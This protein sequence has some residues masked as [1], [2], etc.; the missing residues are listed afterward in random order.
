MS[1]VARVQCTRVSIPLIAPIR[2]PW[3]CRREATRTIV[4]MITDD[5]THGVGET[6]GEPIVAG[7]IEELAPKIIGEDP[8]NLE[9]IMA[10]VQM[11]PYFSGYV[12]YAAIAG[13]EMALWDIQGKELGVPVYKL[14]GGKFRGEVPFAGYVFM[15][16]AGKDGRGGEESPS[17][18]VDFSKRMIG[19]CGFKVIKYK[20]GVMTPEFDLEVMRAL[21]CELGS[22]VGLRIDVNGLWKPQTALR[23]G[24][25]MEELDLEYAEDLT[26]GLDAMASVRREVSIPFATNMCVVT[27]EQI[28]MSV[29]INAIDVILGDVHKWGGILSTK[30][31]AAVC[32]TFSLGMSLH[33]GA[34]LGISTAATL[35]VAAS[36]PHLRFAAD[37]HYH[38]LTDDIIAGGPL[39]YHN[40]FMIVPEGPGLGVEIDQE[41]LQ[42][43]SVEDASARKLEYVIDEARPGWFP[44]KAAW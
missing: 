25:R 21:R 17:A 13:I 35:H 22:D 11:T 27:F 24:K 39:K 30:K 4:Q 8:F 34:E 29:K 20:G 36:T 23:F 37:S 19:E 5:G 15:R 44:E 1:N 14:L 43:Y 12:G 26:W 2:W 38:H 7:I 16:Y 33:S 40:G 10:K 32:E 41:K 28:P 6:L 3:G 18:L 9:R 31:L 42:R